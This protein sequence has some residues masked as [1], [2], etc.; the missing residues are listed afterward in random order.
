MIPGYS[1]AGSSPG[2][3]SSISNASSRPSR[4]RLDLKRCP[5]K[6]GC[7]RLYGCIDAQ[8]GESTPDDTARKPQVLVSPCVSF[9]ASRSH[10]KWG[11]RESPYCL[12]H[13]YGFRTHGHTHS[14]KGPECAIRQHV[15]S[16]SSFDLAIAITVVKRPRD[17]FAFAV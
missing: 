17:E 11:K 14:G 5:W 9:P 4:H 6:L 8:V 3:P 15:D 13:R 7:L 12:R 16:L 2:F 1:G 10:M